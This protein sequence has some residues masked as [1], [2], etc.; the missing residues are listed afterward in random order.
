MCY[1]AACDTLGI[2]QPIL[3]LKSRSNGAITTLR[4]KTIRVCDEH[5]KESTVDSFLSDEGFDKLVRHLRDA[6]KTIPLHR[7]TNLSWER[8]PI[9]PSMAAAKEDSPVVSAGEDLPS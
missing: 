8:A 1:L 5:K 7:L 9:D 6:G 2:W 4:F 3:N